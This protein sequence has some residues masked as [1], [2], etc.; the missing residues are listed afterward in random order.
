MEDK[1]YALLSK[2][3]NFKIIKV[4]KTV[5]ITYCI[6][7]LFSKWVLVIGLLYGF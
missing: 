2:A 5:I 1:N 4:I 6:P 3:V 7:C